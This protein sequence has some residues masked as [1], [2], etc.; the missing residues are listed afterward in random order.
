MRR[1][2]TKAI[3]F[4]WRCNVALG[5]LVEIARVIVVEVGKDEVRRPS[6]V[7]AQFR[8]GVGGAAQELVTSEP[9]FVGVEAGIDE[10]GAFGADRHPAE[11]VHDHRV[12]PG[13]AF[14]IDRDRPSFMP[15]IA[16]AEDFERLR[17][18]HAIS[19]RSRDRVPQTGAVPGPP[20]IGLG[21]ASGDG[22]AAADVQD[23]P[24][25]E[26]RA[27]V[28][29]EGDRVGR[30][31]SVR[32]CGPPARSRRAPSCGDRRRDWRPSTVGS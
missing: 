15:C 28:H 32:P 11:E 24:G 10:D 16:D 14:E 2:V 30:C 22:D 27:F 5:K 8:E 13:R 6:R 17:V 23:L 19:L 25:D 7:R 31:P 3:S 26:A 12:A 29:E 20:G 1:P 21:A 9:S 18:A 4:S